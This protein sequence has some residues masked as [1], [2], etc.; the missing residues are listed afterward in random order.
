MERTTRG[1]LRHA[2]GVVQLRRRRTRPAAVPSPVMVKAVD[3]WR[4]KRAVKRSQVS[5]ARKWPFA[6]IIGA[7]LGVLALVDKGNLTTNGGLSS[8]CR[9]EVVADVLPTR[10]DP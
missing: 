7:L 4:K 3:D 6:V 10:S 2:I 5:F 9:V 1:L 8:P